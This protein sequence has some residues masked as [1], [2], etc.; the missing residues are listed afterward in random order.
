[1]SHGSFTFPI[2]KW[3]NLHITLPWIYIQSTSRSSIFFFDSVLW[4][5][6]TVVC[7]NWVMN[8]LSPPV[9]SQANTGIRS[10]KT[11]DEFIPES[12]ANIPF[13][14]RH[15]T[16][17]TRAKTNYY[18]ILSQNRMQI[19]FLV[20]RRIRALVPDP[21]VTRIA[22]PAC[23]RVWRDSGVPPKDR[24]DPAG[25]EIVTFNRTLFLFSST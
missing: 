23:H 1:M 18:R 21:R 3:I 22:A 5:N 25:G 11:S 4:Q 2:T 20:V 12:E 24:Y 17:V 13:L 15:L 8:F 14:F 6:P 19:Y 10:I 16:V 9:Q 7:H